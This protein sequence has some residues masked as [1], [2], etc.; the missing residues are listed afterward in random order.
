MK[1]Y[2]EHKGYIGTIEFSADDK[3]FYGKLEAINDLV[4]FE[5]ENVIE[6][7]NNFIDAVEDYLVT[8]SEFGKEPNK[9]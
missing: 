9:T 2:L 7:E 3:V 1:N 6:L 5:G 4:T 8:C